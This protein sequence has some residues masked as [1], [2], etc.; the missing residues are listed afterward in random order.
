MV[1]EVPPQG[2]SVE[3]DEP[4]ASGLKLP[5]V[6]SFRA[7]LRHKLEIIVRAHGGYGRG[8]VIRAARALRVSRRTL[9]RWLQWG[10]APRTRSKWA[11]VDD[12]YA[13]SLSALGARRRKT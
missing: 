6:R 4:P 12:L 8:G 13:D 3:T 7:D 11:R 2:L 10:S 1:W 5:R 9:A